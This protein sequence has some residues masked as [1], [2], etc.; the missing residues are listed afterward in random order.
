MQAASDA[1]VQSLAPPPI[2]SAPILA[3]RA[4]HA[5]LVGVTILDLDRTLTRRGTYSPFLLRA[6]WRRAPQRLLL[7]PAV[8]ACMLAYKLKWIDR[9][10]LKQA[11][12]RLMLG[13]GLTR[14]AVSA[15][16]S[17]FADH[18][19]R[20]GLHA[21]TLPLIARERAQGRRIILATAAHRFY[22][23]AIAARLGVDDV[24]ATESRWTGDRLTAAISGPNC[25]GPAKAVAV[26]ARLD[27][28]GLARASAH[29][30]VYSDD[31]S[32]LPCFDEG[33]ECFVVNPCAR[34]AKLAHA[35]AWPILRFR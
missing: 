31:V 5:D 4:A 16:V 12:F 2:A 10:A 14:A 13:P 1:S 30:R 9:T 26:R 32:D 7:V 15:L 34:L 23:E 24:V 19:V 20:E 17:D 29:L 11:M 8:L 35:R 18:V 22:A 25:Y 28:L 6:A 27:D 33:D 3:E 21:E